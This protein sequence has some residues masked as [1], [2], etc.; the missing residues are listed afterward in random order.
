MKELLISFL[1]LTVFIVEL[2][3]GALVILSFQSLVSTKWIL[4]VQDVLKRL[5]WLRWVVPF[6]LLFL[7]WGRAQIYPWVDANSLTDGFPRVYFSPGFFIL[8][9]II[10]LCIWFSLSMWILRSKKKLGGLALVLILFTG[11]FWSFDWILSL[12]PQFRS[13]AFGLV[14]LVSGTLSAFGFAVF[15]HKA[16]IASQALQDINN[17]HFTLVGSW[18]YL[19]FVQFQIIWSGNLPDE[20]A[21]YVVRSNASWQWIPISLVVLQCAVPL[22][23]LLVI[24]WKAD[25]TFTRFF[26][27]LTFTMQMIH[28]FWTV[29]PTIHPEGFFV[30]IF[31][32]L[33]GLGILSSLFWLR[34][35]A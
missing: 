1:F 22:F 3:L 13:T 33:A 8:R 26:G 10:Y 34:R 35:T 31:S 14:F 11:T 18:L 19:W 21:W 28:A 30:S 32:A 23:S 25:P 5:L 20:A 6:L 2:F 27:G 16:E 12:T 4:T 17:V 9:N 15:F 29:V 24:R 7:Y